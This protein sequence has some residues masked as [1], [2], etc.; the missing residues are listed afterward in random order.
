MNIKLAFLLLTVPLFSASLSAQREETLLGERGWGLSGVWGGYKHQ[1]AQFGVNNEAFNRG[2]FFGFEFGKSLYLG[3]GRYELEDA[4]NWNATEGRRFDLRWNAGTLSYAFVPHKAVHPVL[5]V[6]FGRGRAKLQGVGE[7]RIFIVQPSAG[8]EVNV[9]RWLR[10]DL[11]G[12][13]RFIKETDLEPLRDADL[14]GAF[15]Q[16]ALKFGFS[17]GKMRKYRGGK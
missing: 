17:W 14:S 3:W 1:Y 4:F 2:G 8:I 9:F 7:D 11:E 10:L 12:G 16:A 5:N 13:Y 15:G 6:D